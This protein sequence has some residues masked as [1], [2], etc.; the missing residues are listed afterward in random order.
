MSHEGSERVKEQ[1]YV[2]KKIKQEINADIFHESRG[3]PRK[4]KKAAIVLR[5]FK[6]KEENL[7]NV[8]SDQHRTARIA[9]KLREKKRVKNATDINRNKCLT[10]LN[11]LQK[12]LLM[13]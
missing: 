9:R 7:K 4:Y 12:F 1:K 11:E 10:R 8:S 5:D 3:S 6:S 13:G 2:S